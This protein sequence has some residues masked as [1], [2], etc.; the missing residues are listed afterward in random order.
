MQRIIKIDEEKCSGCGICVNVCHESAIQMVNGKAKLVR[1]D[2]CDGLGDCLPACPEGAIRFEEKSCCRT[3][4]SAEEEYTCGCIG[5]EASESGTCEQI[6]QKQWPMQLK[7]VPLTADFYDNADLLIAA[8]CC[9]F[10]YENFH[11]EFLN[12]KV[13]LIG[14]QKLDQT[15]YSIKISE[16]LK[17][18]NIKSVSAVRMNVPCC[19]SIE[20]AAAEA[21]KLSGKDYRLNVSVITTEGRLAGTSES[22]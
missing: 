12:D 6:R 9:A 20:R 3:A 5:E 17:K 13:V 11:K 15:D 8:D 14:C 10:S 21:I 2:F 18:N 1:E 7:L 22:I 16:I 4:G 19:G